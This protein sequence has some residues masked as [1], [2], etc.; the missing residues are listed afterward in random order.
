MY[1]VLQ[2]ILALFTFEVTISDEIITEER[3]EV[4]VEC[5]FSTGRAPLLDE[6]QSI[7]GINSRDKLFISLLHENGDLIHN[8]S[9]ENGDDFSAFIDN[10]SSTLQSTDPKRIIIKIEKKRHDNKISVYYPD[11]F[12]KHLSTKPILILLSIL[13]NSIDPNSQY[14]I[15]EI[16]NESFEEFS[17]S[18]IRF[19]PQGYTINNEPDNSYRKERIRKITNLCHCD[20]FSK[21]AFIP[22]D[23]SPYIRSENEYLSKVFDKLKLL[24]SIIF[25]FDIVEFKN[26]EIKYKLNGY[27]TITQ[28]ID[29]DNVDLDSHESYYNIYKWV[30]DG[31]NVVDK[32]GLARN[33]LSL[34]FAKDTLHL[35]EMAFDAIKSGYKV[36]Q[37]ENIKQYIEVRN[38]ISDQLI[39]L[40]DKADEIVAA[41]VS[42]YKKSIFTILSFFITVIVIE[43]VS[44][45]SYTGGF[46]IEITLLSIGF[47]LISLCLMFFSRWEINKELVRYNDFYAN[48][49]ERYTD[50]LDSSDINRILNGDKDF[51]SNQSFIKERKSKYTALWILSLSILLIIIVS[52]Y[53]INNPCVANTAAHI[54]KIL[55][56]VVL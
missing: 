45:G 50:L 16:Q 10:C 4:N 48:L 7:E 1:N 18:A 43:V 46:T 32:I 31:G 5:I 53:F 9:Q 19:V 3:A 54:I 35:S 8:Y 14:I 6:F 28:I 12:V 37:K 22:E 33:I 38:K 23:F 24:Y 30:Y 42:D 11:L 25:L 13:N 51:Q 55:W 15:F 39:E 2:Q 17:S 52:L 44:N 34:N 21:Y 47:L 41:F 20:L 26:T 27:R 40:Q 29:T 36:Y 56:Y 49:K